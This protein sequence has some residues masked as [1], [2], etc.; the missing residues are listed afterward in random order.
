M[1]ATFRDAVTVTRDLGL[2][3][4]WIDSL[5]IIQDDDQD[6]EAES[7]KMGSIFDAAHIV[8]GASSSPDP[9]Q[10]FLDSRQTMFTDHLELNY[11]FHQTQLRQTF[12]G[13]YFSFYLH[14]RCGL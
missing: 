3:Y 1:P 6:W 11:L 4:L 9:D 7:A 13:S 14:F 2:R 8:I 12:F 10:S 5:C